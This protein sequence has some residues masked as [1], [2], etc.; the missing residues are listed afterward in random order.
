VS[1]EILEPHDRIGSRAIEA[2]P[3]N[4]PPIIEWA[5][6]NVI[7]ASSARSKYFNAGITP[8]IRE[9]IERMVD[10]TTRCVTFMKPVQS[11]GSTFGE[12]VMLYWIMFWRGFLQYNWSNDKRSDE[13]WASRIRPL[14]EQCLPEKFAK[15]TISGKG[16]VD[17]GNV[18]F[19]MQGVFV[20]SNLDS[21]TI[22]LQLNEEIHDWEKGHLKK[23]EGRSTAV[24]NFKRGNI[25]NAGVRKDQLDQAHR[26]GTMQQWEVWCPGCKKYHVLRTK[27]DE[28]RPDLGGLRYDATN[29]RRGFFEYDYNKMRTTIF[30]SMP[31]GF[32]VPNEDL[33]MRRG[34][35]TSGKWSDPRNTGALLSNRS[36]SYDAVIVD[37]IDWMTLIQKK[38]EALKSRAYGD[39]APW[40]KYCQEQECI[41]Y[42]PNDVPSMNVTSVVTGL[43]KSREGLP[44]PRL[45]LFSLDRQQ[46]EAKKGELPYWWLCIRDFKVEGGKLKSRLVYEDKHEMDQD[47]IARL[48]EHKCNRWQG[49]ADSGDDTTYV[50]TFCIK[51]G[52]NAIKGGKTIFYTHDDQSR[53]IYSQERP[54]HVMLNRPPNFDYVEVETNEGV[55]LMPDPREPM[56]WL[57]SK[58][59]IRER[60]HSLRTYTDYQT[61]DDVSD[62][63][64]SHQEAE[65]REE[66]IIPSDGSRVYEWVQYKD[67]ND[68]FVNE[69]YI[70]MQADK[71]GLVI[72]EAT[73]KQENKENQ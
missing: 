43:K 61:P 65:Q 69:C 15:S 72:L 28:K 17:F 11:G 31:C 3:K 6:S 48:D 2:I 16:D 57:Y 38:H 25:S 59:G 52:I 44:A 73:E 10:L 45:R 41:P 55:V 37:Y 21:D 29:C 32:R 56:F 66:R 39:I 67:R 47:V 4:N 20:S 70:A 64:K 49:C 19:R 71:A 68:Q 12:V 42:D 14:F 30:Y 54:L 5:E 46:G 51:Y 24:W 7:L 58:Q 60:L 1:R 63:Y 34:L 35:S 22:P 27:W 13:R 53:H 23:A 36:Y 9:P 40:I 26:E 33:I 18:F 8:W 50:Y 62:E